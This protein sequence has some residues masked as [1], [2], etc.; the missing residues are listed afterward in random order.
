MRPGAREELEALVNRLIDERVA[1]ETERL[2]SHLPR[3]TDDQRDILAHFAGRPSPAHS[4][5]GACRPLTAGRGAADCG[6]GRSRSRLPVNP[7]SKTACLSPAAWKSLRHLSTPAFFAAIYTLYAMTSSDLDQTYDIDLQA[8]DAYAA[9]V[10][11][12]DLMQAA[13]RTLR[14]AGRRSGG[15]TIVITGD[16]S[17]DLNRTYRRWRA[18]RRA[19]FSEQEAGEDGPA[20][21]LPPNW[22]KR[23]AYLGD[24]V[25]AYPY[26]ERQAARSP[27]PCALNCACSWCTARCICSAMTTTRRRRSAHGRR[28]MRCWSAWAKRPKPRTYDA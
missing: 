28:K 10:D 13:A 26:T 17:A 4:V 1:E 7:A 6:Y 12:G 14:M 22:R 19:Q 23:W 16:G 25:I 18:H 5:S 9:A 15:L 8:D 11:A 20:L 24:I 2:Q 3:V 27:T 21:A